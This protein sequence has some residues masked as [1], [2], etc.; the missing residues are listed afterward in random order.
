MFDPTIFDNLKVITEGA[1]YDLDFEGKV[2]VIDRSDFVDLAKMSRHYSITFKEDPGD[3]TASLSVIVNN[4]DLFSE[5]LETRDP[6]DIGCDFIV[7][8][9]VPINDVENDCETIKFLMARK[10]RKYQT[11]IKQEIHTVYKSND[12]VNHITLTFP[13][14]ITE[15]DSDEIPNVIETIY[16]TIQSL[17]SYING[18]K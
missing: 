4:H 2:T 8:L 16:E 17:N 12:Y 11:H 1:V 18:D 3:T 15:D 5:L 6:E 14:P 13:E 7:H 10:W 9:K